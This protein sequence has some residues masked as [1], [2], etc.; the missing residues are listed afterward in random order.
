M[1]GE[2]LGGGVGEI[3]TQAHRPIQADWDANTTERRD[4]CVCVGR[5]GGGG[6]LNNQVDPHINR[7]LP[8][9]G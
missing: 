9:G 7:E 1:D 3:A 8:F 5:R 2:T 4:V 6:L